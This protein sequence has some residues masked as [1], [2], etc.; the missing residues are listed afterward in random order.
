MRERYQSGKM[1]V[2]FKNVDCV[3]VVKKDDVYELYYLYKPKIKTEK[4][5]LLKTFTDVALMRKYF[6]NMNFYSLGNYFINVDNFE[7]IEELEHDDDKKTQTV[8]IYMKNTQP[9]TV[10]LDRTT[11]QSFK[12]TRMA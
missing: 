6:G 4:V 8:K 3:E 12:N 1:I 10:T 5:K 2:N 11:W 9:I 7:I